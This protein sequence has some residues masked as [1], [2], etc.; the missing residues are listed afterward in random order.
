MASIDVKVIQTLFDQIIGFKKEIDNAGE[1]KR[2]KLNTINY[3]GVVGK[4]PRK[5]D[6]TLDEA[7]WESMTEDQQQAIIQQTQQL[8]STLHSIAEFDG[9]VDPKNIMYDEYAS[10]SVILA[11]TGSGMLII[12]FLLFIIS[13]TWDQATGTISVHRSSPLQQRLMSS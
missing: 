1:E 7:G 12:I 11:M 8:C 6:G 3:D 2:N 4:I 9:P 13:Y 10:K 5:D